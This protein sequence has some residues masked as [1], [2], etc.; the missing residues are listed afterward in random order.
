M[1]NLTLLRIGISI[2]SVVRRK[3]SMDEF[4]SVIMLSGGRKTFG[5]LNK[6]LG[7]IVDN[8]LDIQG[9]KGIGN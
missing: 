2:R 5:N 9:N 7:I 3:A 6:Y 1:L 8:S 4:N